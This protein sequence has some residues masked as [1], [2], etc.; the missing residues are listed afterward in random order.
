MARIRT[1]GAVLALSVAVTVCAGSVALAGALGPKKASQIIS[2]SCSE[3][4]ATGDSGPL[5]W[6]KLES[7][8]SV[9]N[10]YS[11]P[12]GQVLV[13][14]SMTIEGNGGAAGS[15]AGVIW[16]I[17]GPGGYAQMGYLTTTYDSGNSASIHKEFPTGWAVKSGSL[18]VFGPLSGSTTG[19][20]QAY[21]TGYLAADK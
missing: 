9:T 7:D 14:T 11:I 4:C 13:I 10:N 8:G 17:V 2:L 20:D 6:A 15:H 1:V 3:G 21:V 12:A 18:P 16:G 19:N 5:S